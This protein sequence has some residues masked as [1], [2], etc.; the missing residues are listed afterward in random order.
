M[1]ADR[2]NSIAYVISHTIKNQK[3]SLKNISQ[4]EKGGL[5]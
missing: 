1:N 2:V 4:T 5:I 3:C